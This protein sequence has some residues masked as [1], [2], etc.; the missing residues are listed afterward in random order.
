MSIVAAGIVMVM[1][2]QREEGEH[3]AEAQARQ[4]TNPGNS[5]KPSN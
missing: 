1:W 5:G 3:M 2:Y 4:R